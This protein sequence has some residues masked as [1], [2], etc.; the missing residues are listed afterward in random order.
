MADVVVVGAGMAGL[1]AAVHLTEA[2]FEVLVLEASDG[3]GG[4]VRT[5]EVDGFRLDR[6]FQVYLTA[7]PE[8]TRILDL[9]AL[10]LQPFEPGAVVWTDGALHRVAD[11]LRRPGAMPATLRAPIGSFSDKLRVAR[12]RWSIGRG[13]PGDLLGGPDITT[14]EWLQAEGFTSRMIERFF[15]PLLGGITLDRDLGGPARVS[16]FV[17]RMLTDGAAAVPGAGMGAIPQQLAGRLPRGALRLH[18]R[19]EALDERGVVLADGERIDTPAVVVATEGPEAARLAGIDPVGSKAIAAF[20]FAAAEPPFA[21]PILALDGDGD[22]TVCTVAPMSTVAP[23]YAP[24]GRALIAVE[25][26]LDPAAGEAPVR[27]RLR[28]M[29]GSPADDWELLRSDVISHAQPRRD[30]PFVATLPARLGEGRYVAGDHRTT[31]S[32]NGALR[33]GRLAAEAVAAGSVT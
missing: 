32:I 16:T 28:E 11:P 21:D 2:G 31:P 13:D 3:V 18:S 8:G 15:R 9:E 27:A 24:P 6:G 17:L 14:M 10:D 23:G 25:S 20:W 33:S 12:L 22:G 5:D 29:F 19:V 30:P 26:F 1:A 4:R 7:Y